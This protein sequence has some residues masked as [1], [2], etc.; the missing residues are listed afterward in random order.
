MEVG[1]GKKETK[2]EEKGGVGRKV[3][4]VKGRRNG[5]GGGIEVEEN[6]DKARR[7]KR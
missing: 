7:K 3:K 1:K 5:S 2:K 4:E 6:N